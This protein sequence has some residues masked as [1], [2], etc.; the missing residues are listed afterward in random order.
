[1]YI[2]NPVTA[3]NWEKLKGVNNMLKHETFKISTTNI[4]YGLKNQ[5][6]RENEFKTLH[7][8]TRDLT[9]ISISTF[10]FRH[11]LHKYGTSLNIYTR[12][13]MYI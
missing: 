11:G 10:K 7:D 8:F 3:L 5:C 2:H 4:F 6:L 12:Q 13:T 1:M 9:T